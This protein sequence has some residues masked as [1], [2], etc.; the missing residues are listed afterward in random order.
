[1]TKKTEVYNDAILEGMFL[2]HKVISK[3]ID[4]LRQSLNVVWSIHYHSDLITPDKKEMADKLTFALDTLSVL[5]DMFQGSYLEKID[6]L[7]STKEDFS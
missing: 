4:C 7:K 3:E 1:M 2:C 5:D 6:K